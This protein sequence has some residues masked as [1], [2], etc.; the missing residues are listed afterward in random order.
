MM[1][2]NRSFTFFL[3]LTITGFAEGQ[4]NIGKVIPN[5]V[6]TTIKKSKVS[7]NDTDKE[8]IYFSTLVPKKIVIEE[9]E[10]LYNELG[11]FEKDKKIY[12]SSI[13]TKG[14]LL[15]LITSI[16]K[17]DKRVHVYIS[18]KDELNQE[19]SI[20][21]LQESFKKILM[22]KFVNDYIK[23]L[24]KNIQKTDKKQNKIIRNNPNNLEMNSSFFYKI[25][26]KKESK[27]IGLKSALEKLYEEL[28]ETKMIYNSIE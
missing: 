2:L 16:V 3:L 20:N 14:E 23:E 17:K 5:N 6:F 22:R 27:K 12:N 7:F 18:D 9:L 26:Q 13:Q 4:T 15:A 1:S 21:N 24:E 8:A 28:E 19:I 25:Y 10:S 11:S